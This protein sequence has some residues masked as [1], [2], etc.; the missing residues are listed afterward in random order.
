MARRRGGGGGGG[1]MGLALPI[2]GHH[3]V[4]ELLVLGQRADQLQQQ[5][6]VGGCG[7]ADGDHGPCTCRSATTQEWSEAQSWRPTSKPTK[8]SWGLANRRS[9][10]IQRV[11]PTG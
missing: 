4:R 2:G 11:R 5:W 6:R 1:S 3:L 9:R 7:G 8:R 10:R